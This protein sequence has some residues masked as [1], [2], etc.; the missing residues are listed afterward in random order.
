MKKAEQVGKVD[1]EPAVKTA[2]VDSATHKS[3]VPFHHHEPLAL[4][5]LHTLP[6]ISAYS[7]SPNAP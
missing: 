7:P 3:I 2:G 6:D 4:E 5:A 1:P